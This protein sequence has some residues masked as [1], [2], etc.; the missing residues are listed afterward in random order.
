MSASRLRNFHQSWK[1]QWALMVDRHY[2]ERMDYKH[3]ADTKKQSIIDKARLQI[4]S[5]H[6]RAIAPRSFDDQAQK[7]REERNAN[8]ELIENEYTEH[9]RIIGEIQQKEQTDHE[10]AY[11]EAIAARSFMKGFPAVKPATTASS[12]N[13]AGTY[14]DTPSTSRTSATKSPS[15]SNEMLPTKVPIPTVTASERQD[16]SSM[17]EERLSCTIRSESTDGRER[18]VPP[19]ATENRQTLKEHGA[20]CARKDLPTNASVGSVPTPVHTASAPN[21]ELEA[22]RTITFEE[23]YQDGRAEHKD[24]II[25]YPCGSR[26]WYILKCEEHRIRFNQRPL[27]GAAK[28]LSGKGHGHLGKSQAIAIKK[29]GFRVVNCNEELMEVNNKAVRDAFANGYKPERMRLKQMHLISKPAR[30]DKNLARKTLPAAKSTLSSPGQW[31][32]ESREQPEKIITNPKA[33]HIYCCLWELDKVYPVLILGWNDLKPGGLTTLASTGLLNKNSQPPNCYLYR[34]P[35][36]GMDAAIVGWAPGFEDGGPKVN[37][38]KFP[39]MFFDSDNEVGWVPAKSLSRFPLDKLSPPKSGSYF[40]M[41]RQWIAKNRGFATWE[42]FDKARKGKA[43][44]EKSPIVAAKP[45]SPLSETVDSDSDADTESHAG[46][47]I[48]RITEKELQELQDKAGEIAGDSDYAAS[49]IGSSSEDEDQVWEHGHVGKRPWAFYNLREKTQT[50]PGKAAQLPPPK[51]NPKTTRTNLPPQEGIGVARNLLQTAVCGSSRADDWLD[52]VG[53]GLETLPSEKVSGEAIEAWV[54]DSDSRAPG[55]KPVMGGN[56]TN[57]TKTRAGSAKRSASP[58][59]ITQTNDNNYR[60]K[61]LSADSITGPS[62]FVAQPTEVPQGVTWARTEERTK[63]ANDVSTPTQQ[64]AA[65]RLKTGMAPY[66]NP[67]V[68]PAVLEPP[69]ASGATVMPKPLPSPSPPAQLNFKPKSPLGPVVFEL[70]FYR[71]GPI[72]WSRESEDFAM[73]LYYGEDDTM[74]G[75]VEGPV[76][77]VINPMMLKGLTQERIPESKGNSIVTLL[78]KNPGD[79]SMELVFDRARGSRADIGKVQVRSLIRWVKRVNP[80]F[81]LPQG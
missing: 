40:D 23:V 13:A 51:K 73:K 41:A 69:S 56:I 38:R 76:D 71:K 68:T 18:E 72:S 42:E 14:R 59:Q 26:Q 19:S 21:N 28:H 47:F 9:M 78:G 44:D 15:P 33:F 20:S 46:S 34:G 50:S 11:N 62:L 81:R 48:S 36:N 16:Q 77:V 70:S 6:N 29:L 31:H 74:V 55:D 45:I 49:D 60:E 30:K 25:E 1:K 75:T 3:E 58:T 63:N 64:R 67:V 79:A 17:S 65:K 80:A 22:S 52:K 39:A 4:E 54:Q 37:Q 57:T 43:I 24:T 32:K 8:L 10:K 12:S 35:G 5:L 27:Q 61:S 66:D 53:S 7:I 2:D